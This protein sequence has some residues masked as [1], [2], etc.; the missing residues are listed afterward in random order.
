MH[1]TLEKISHQKYFQ[2]YV[3]IAEPF[4]AFLEILFR[5]LLQYISIVQGP[6]ST[7]SEWDNMGRTG[8][9]IIKDCIRQICVPLE[10][11]AYFGDGDD[12]NSNPD[13]IYLLHTAHA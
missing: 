6:N 10:N 7:F 12:V 1:S 2:F 11:S 8:N 5:C 13:C 9:K 3:T 4:S